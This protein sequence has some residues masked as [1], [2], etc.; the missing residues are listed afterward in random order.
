MLCTKGLYLTRIKKEAERVRGEGL[1][2]WERD[3][4]RMM[5]VWKKWV[6]YIY[7]EWV[8]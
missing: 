1:M 5:E 7:N 4:E 3:R 6:G 2:E 8:G